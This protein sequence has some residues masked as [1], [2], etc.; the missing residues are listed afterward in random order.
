M[1]YFKLWLIKHHPIKLDDGD[2]FISTYFNPLTKWRFVVSF[3]LRSL[4]RGTRIPAVCLDTSQ[5]RGCDD[6]DKQ[7]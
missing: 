3:K 2:K 6:K 4:F 7:P 1:V 5:S